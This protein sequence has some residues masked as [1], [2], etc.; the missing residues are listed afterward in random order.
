MSS[1]PANTTD[2]FTRKTDTELLYFLQ[3]PELYHADVVTAARQELHRR[4]A[5]TRSHLTDTESFVTDYDHEPAERRWLAPVIGGALLVV[6]GFLYNQFY[7]PSPAF[8]VAPKA[9]IELKSVELNVLPTFDAETA[10]QVKQEPSLLPTKERTDKKPLGKYLILAG[11]F[12][13]AENQ[14]E[15]L[16]DQVAIAKIDSTF[17]GKTTLVYDQWRELTR[18]LVYNHN[19]R[20]A[21]QERV[22]MMHDIANRRMQ[23]LQQMRDNY[24]LGRPPLDKEV[25][26]TLAPVADMLYELRGGKQ[27]TRHI[28]LT[29]AR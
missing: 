17:L 28:D 8:A 9:P 14:A 29:V 1:S 26:N 12:W 19:L 2:L 4:G 24:A 27:P 3:H 18:V 5:A 13:K 22:N 23:S 11:R 15:F 20:P 21:M 25:R 7:R 6:G 16:A 10:A